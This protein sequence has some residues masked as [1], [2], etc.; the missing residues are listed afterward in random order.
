MTLWL[1]A[2]VLVSLITREPTSH[3]IDDL[4]YQEIEMPFVSDFCI[5]ECSSAIARLVRIG[6]RT[7]GEADELF[8]SL[9]LWIETASAPI[10][11]ESEDIALATAFVRRPGISLRAPDAIHIAAAHRLGATLLTLDLGM[12]RAAAALG[13]DHLNPAE[14][15]APGEPKD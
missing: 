2:S 1:D 6:A 8:Q 13:V 10:D 4:L 3:Q 12:A 15:D 11:V 5:A 7:A 14:A 9:D